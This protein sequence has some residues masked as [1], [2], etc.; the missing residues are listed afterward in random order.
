MVSNSLDEQLVITHIFCKENRKRRA[1]NSKTAEEGLL[2]ADGGH[3]ERWRRK[4]FC[5]KQQL[6]IEHGLQS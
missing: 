6:Q 5:G 2:A 1:I 4:V 3:S